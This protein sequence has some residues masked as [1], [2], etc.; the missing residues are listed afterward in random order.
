MGIRHPERTGLPKSGD[1][2][3]SRSEGG[4]VSS[5]SRSA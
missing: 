5:G 2:A 1:A 4:A 3:E